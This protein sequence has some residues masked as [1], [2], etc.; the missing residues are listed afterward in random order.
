MTI[1]TRLGRYRVWGNLSSGARTQVLLAT[2]PGKGGFEQTVV[3]KR[4][5]PG[6]APDGEAVRRL[7]NEA[8]TTARLRH[9][10]VAT[11][12]DVVEIDGEYVVVREHV[13]GWSVRAIV[14]S[15]EAARQFLPLDVA[16]AI[17][18]A[19]SSAIQFAH[20]SGVVH[21][22]VG[23][24]HLLVGHGGGV[25][26]I[27]FGQARGLD[28]RRGRRGAYAGGP[29]RADALA[30][31][32]DDVRGLGR[33]LYELVTS[34][35]LS[36][37]APGPGGGH[38]HEVPWTIAPAASSL[39]PDVPRSLDAILASALSPSPSRRFPSAEALA[40][41]LEA[42][43]AGNGFVPSP[44]RVAAALRELDP[45]F[46]R[47]PDGDGERTRP[48]LPIPVATPALRTRDVAVAVPA[49]GEREG[50]TRI[51]IKRR[52]GHRAAGLAL[53]SRAR[54]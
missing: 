11:I 8:R 39:R 31:R 52:S 40:C 50:P 34:L 13:E 19:A 49:A 36:R 20:D 37:H 16:V 41:A 2:A 32:D 27:G 53:H 28:A 43:A 9:P 1:P 17:V 14:A 10:N 54:G 48:D 35:P 46:D 15:L 18:H 30:L 4:L 26:S 5:A 3:L 33:I 51:R 45:A 42:F 44:L 24:S 38:D 29:A 7:L 22:R 6:T 21:G 23:P 25:K 12:H 47:A